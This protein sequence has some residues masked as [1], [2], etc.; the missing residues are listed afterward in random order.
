MLI[1]RV[2]TACNP[3]YTPVRVDRTVGSM[4]GNPFVLRWGAKGEQREAVCGA[5]EE[6]LCESIALGI[7][8]RLP[9]SRVAEIGA[10]HG[11]AEA[12]R[13]WNSGAAARA[14][15]RLRERARG[16]ERLALMCHCAPLR[17]HAESLKSR[18]PK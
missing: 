6:L 7:D 3:D 5:Y 11:C 18:M 16:G 2:G 13:P 9:S 14:F 4:L 1:C 15:Y 17:C 8:G 12:P 10:G